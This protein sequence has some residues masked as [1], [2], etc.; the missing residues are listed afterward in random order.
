MRIFL[1]SISILF[2]STA[3][4]VLSLLFSLSVYAISDNNQV[5]SDTEATQEI[6]LQMKPEVEYLSAPP[7]FNDLHEINP[8]VCGWITVDG[9][10]IDYPVLQGSSNLTYLNKD[11]FGNF[12]LAG[13][14]FLDAV[15]DYQFGDKYSLI[16]GH[17]MDNHLM[18][19]DLDLFKDADFF[20]QN[21]YATLLTLNESIDMQ[22]LAIM[23]TS[24]STEEIFH[25]TMWNGD[26][27]PLVAYIKDNSMYVDQAAYETALDNIDS[28]R[29]VALATCTDGATGN[30]SVLFL[31]AKNGGNNGGN[32]G[33]NPNL[34]GGNIDNPP[35]GQQDKPIDTDYVRPPAKTGDSFSNSPYF[36]LAI[37]VGSM[38]GLLI[39][40]TIRRRQL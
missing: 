25:P 28:L 3:V 24:D 31:I 35:A 30:R 23:E 1:K 34:G 9:T 21:R 29:I 13:S 33:S 16:Y 36:W 15:N 27:S 37:F 4:I 8:D 11:V 5:F 17:H 12:S 19:G 6:M 39:L 7:D 32:S 2:E 10:N 22:V 18:F 14:I 20:Q 26:I 40:V 38:M